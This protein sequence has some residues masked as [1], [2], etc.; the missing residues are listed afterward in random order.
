MR[1]KELANCQLALVMRRLRR[2]ERFAYIYRIGIDKRSPEESA[3][4]KRFRAPIQMLERGQEFDAEMTLSTELCVAR[5]V[6]V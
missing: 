2:V 3:K 5:D 6:D 4:L 1:L